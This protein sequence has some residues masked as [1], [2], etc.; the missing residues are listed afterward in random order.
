LG[1]KSKISKGSGIRASGAEG[2][3]REKDRKRV[4]T[5]GNDLTKNDD[6]I[7]RKKDEISGKTLRGESGE[8]N[9]QKKRKT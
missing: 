7:E 1:E 5:D 9:S 3:S 8:K 4:G 6:C 2:S